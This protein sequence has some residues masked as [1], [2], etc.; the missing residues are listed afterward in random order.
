[1]SFQPSIIGTGLVGWQ[2]LQSTQERQ[3][4]V[5]NASP[6]L[7]RDTEYF[8]ENIGSVLTAEDLVSDRRLLR[9]ALG[10]FGLQDDINN[11]FFIQKVLEEGATDDTALANRLSD[12]RYKS[13]AEAFG[14]DTVFPGPLQSTFSDD[15]IA[16]FQQQEF[17]VAVGEQD[18]ALRL[19]M[20]FQRGLVEISEAGST[21]DAK[22]FRLMG[23]PPVRTVME[24]A[25]GLPSSFGQLDIDEQLEVFRDKATARFGVGEI[26]ELIAEEPMND[27]VQAYLL[28]DQINQFSATTSA[29][30]TALTLL[31]NIAR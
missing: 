25:L 29:A 10:A 26:D 16:R 28:R 20:N 22:W 27:V 3:R 7:Q 21:D 8:A 13:M 12:D 23:T 17:E 11:K 24:T 14:F 31:Q 2:F 30:Q 4:E 5:F 19:A 1:M 9:V 6:L 15:I 18:Q